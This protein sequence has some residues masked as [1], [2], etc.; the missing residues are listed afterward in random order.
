MVRLALH[1]RLAHMVMKGSELGAGVEASELAALIS[2]RDLLRHAEGVQEADIRSRLDVLRGITVRGDVDGEALRRVRRE[3]AALRRHCAERSPLGRLE[4]DSPSTGLLLAF[5]YPDRI[6]RRRKGQSGRYLLRNGVGAFIEPQ[7][8]AQEEWLAVAE[9]DGRTKESRILLAAPL[10]EAELWE[11]FGSQVEREDL[12]QWDPTTRAV[13]ARRRERLGALVLREA[14]LRDPDPERVKQ[15]LLDVVRK[16]GLELLPWADSVRG[17]RDRVRFLHQLDRSWPDFSDQGLAVSLETWLGPH[18]TG[19]RRLEDLGLLDFTR[20]LEGQLTRQQRV[21]LDQV[22]P[23]H[24]EVP[25][26]SRIAVDYSNPEAPVLAVR[27]QEVFGWR[28]A[29]RI[30]QGRVPLTL[31]LLS[32]AR[33]PVQVTRD[34]AGF[35]QT[36]YFEVRKELK[37]RYPKHYWPDDPLSAEPIRKAGRTRR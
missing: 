2:E 32:P 31:H 33:R 12:I 36:M 28:D 1:P 6:G 14:P 37:G 26:G 4:G 11:H 25:S 10:E 34:L 24:V 30:G 3:V 19:V 5:A 13:V 17:L 8:L 9:L 7:V 23:T 35:W 21:A 27:L 29:P 22:A 15:K 16:E 18:L 20:I